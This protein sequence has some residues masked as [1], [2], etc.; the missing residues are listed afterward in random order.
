MHVHSLRCRTDCPVG[1][2][3]FVGFSKGLLGLIPCAAQ[4]IQTNGGLVLVDTGYGAGRQ[5]PRHAA[6]AAA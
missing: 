1:G 4:L 3:L 5:S 6:Q 2:A